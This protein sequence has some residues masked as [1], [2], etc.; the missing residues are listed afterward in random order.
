MQ[1]SLDTLLVM[2][3]AQQRI[4]RYTPQALRIFE[5]VP[6]DIGRPITQVP[7]YVKPRYLKRRLTKVIK[8]GELHQETLT[9]GKFSYA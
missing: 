8:T 6:T 3:D 9:Q 5:L 1:V 4:V 2:V 7:T